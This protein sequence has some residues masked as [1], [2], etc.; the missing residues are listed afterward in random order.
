MICRTPEEAF[1]AGM[2]AGK[3]D[4]PLSQE[5]ADLAAWLLRPSEPKQ[6]AA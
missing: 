4:P 2:A 5:Q 3:D 1:A 6:A